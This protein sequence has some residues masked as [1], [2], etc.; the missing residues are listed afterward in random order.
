MAHDSAFL[1]RCEAFLLH[2]AVRALSLAQRVDFL[3]QKVLRAHSFLLHP[4][5]LAG[6]L[7]YVS[8][9]VC[10]MQRIQGLSPEEIT[11]CLKSVE[12]QNGLSAVLAPAAA[13]ASAATGGALVAK[14][15][16]TTWTGALVLLVKRYGIVAFLTMLLGYGYVRFRQ[17]A[18]EQFVLK[19]SLERVQRRARRATKVENMLALINEQQAQYEQVRPCVRAQADVSTRLTDCVWW[20]CRLPLA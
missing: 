15:T 6:W 17:K 13:A 12:T 10:V 19:S 20:W 9:L 4:R 14:R 1:A 2:P 8:A 3:E 7:T 11:A 5:C 16:A 18:L